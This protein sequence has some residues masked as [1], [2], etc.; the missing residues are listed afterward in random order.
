MPKRPDP[1]HPLAQASKEFQDSLGLP[2]S[3]T[4]AAPQA[5]VTEPAPGVVTPP[6]LVVAPDLTPAPSLAVDPNAKMQQMFDTMMGRVDALNEVN[7]KLNADLETQINN[8]AFLKQKAEEERAA[9]EAI[10]E[11]ARRLESEAETANATKAFVSDKVDP[12]Q[13]AEVFR[14]IQPHL[15]RRDQQIEEALRRVERAEQVARDAVTA[16]DNKIGKMKQDILERNLVRGAPE[17]KKLLTQPD[18][19]EF[20]NQ[21]IPGA[22]RTRLQELQD[23]YAESDEEFIVNLVS[24]F[25]LLGKPAAAPAVDP[26]RTIQTQTPKAPVKEETITDD[27]VTAAFQEHL[28]GNLTKA[29]YNQLRAQQKKQAAGA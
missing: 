26:P 12:E 3:P 1:N 13:F 21:R 19:Q 25:K 2:A 28:A 9:R 16:A 27:M 6:A 5:P 14:G 24:D 23:A 8:N 11:K 4:A 20:L 15:A 29:Q 18:F 22:R 10:A 17:I 7:R